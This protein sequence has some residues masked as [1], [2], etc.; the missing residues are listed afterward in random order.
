MTKFEIGDESYT[1]E[2]N[3]TYDQ[4]QPIGDSPQAIYTEPS[5]AEPID[6]KTGQDFL[7]IDLGEEVKWLDNPNAFWGL[8][9]YC[10]EDN[11][12][13]D[14]HEK[15]LK[16]HEAI[17][18][19]T[20]RKIKYDIDITEAPEHEGDLRRWADNLGVSQEDYIKVFEESGYSYDWE[21]AEEKL[22]KDGTGTAT[23]RRGI[24]PKNKKHSIMKFDYVSNSDCPICKEYDG[25]TF[26]ADSPNRPVI[27]RLES[28]GNR[29]NR[30]YTHPNCKCRWT[31]I[32]TEALDSKLLDRGEQEYGDGWDDLT[33]LEQNM[34]I[35]KLLQK[36][37]SEEGGKPFSEWTKDDLYKSEC[38]SCG[39]PKDEHPITENGETHEFLPEYPTD[40]EGNMSPANEGGKGSGKLGHQRWMLNAEVGESCDN[41]MMI[42]E[43]ENG[44][45]MVC[46][47]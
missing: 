12:S 5:N 10:G 28:Q 36:S 8:C 16:S 44:V 14:E 23:A 15:H 45:C 21:N 38:Q 17:D 47:K 35:I 25:M 40:Y 6:A 41:C 42:T 2:V 7:D 37:L 34:V 43:R 9:N 33:N 3:T 27:P 26:P 11:W 39:A 32:F 19:E 31:R 30:P 24:D 29:G 1:E 13:V 4:E 22:N 20:R 18:E 46:M